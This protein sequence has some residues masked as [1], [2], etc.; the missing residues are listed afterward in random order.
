MQK[1]K[2]EKSYTIQDEQRTTKGNNLA[3]VV[4]EEADF[5]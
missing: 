1:T 5:R 3:V 4:G 2:K